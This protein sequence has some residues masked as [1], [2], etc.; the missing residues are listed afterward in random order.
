MLERRQREHTFTVLCVPL[1]TT[2]TRLMLGFQVLFVFLWECDT[3]QPNV[4]P[5]PQISHFAIYYTSKK[6]LVF[7]LFLFNDRTTMCII[8]PKPLK[9]KTFFNFF[10]FFSYCTKKFTFLLYLYIS[11][12]ENLLITINM[13]TY[14]HFLHGHS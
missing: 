13:L 3:L 12:L 5:F 6:V 2:L 8:T 11:L 9:C 7:L 14:C 10:Y 1:S 4:T